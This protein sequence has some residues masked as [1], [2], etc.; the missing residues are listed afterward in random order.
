M[1]GD[2]RLLA[3][4]PEPVMSALRPSLARVQL[5]VG[6]VLAEDG[7]QQPFA[8]FPEDAVCSVMVYTEDGGSLEVGLIGPEGVVSTATFLSNGVSVGEVVVQQTG[9][10]QRIPASVLRQAFEELPALRSILL[11]YTQAFMTQVAQSC[12]CNSLHSIRQRSARWLLMMCDRVQAEEFDLSQGL[13]A[14][15]LGVGRP[16][17][18]LATGE[19]RDASLIRFSRGRVAI[20]DRLGLE[21]SAC[22]CYATIASEFERLLNADEAR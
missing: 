21:S 15:M 8:Y 1:A 4:L 2:N 17:V 14:R 20:L 19:L 3:M 12:A 7:V 18:S 11:R 22:G 6:Q 5:E 10:A 9:N 13:M 16:T